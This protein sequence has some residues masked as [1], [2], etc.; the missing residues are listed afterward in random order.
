[1]RFTESMFD[2]IFQTIPQLSKI[3]PVADKNGVVHEVNFQ[4]PR[5][6]VDYVQQIQKD[7]GIDVSQYMPEDE[8]QLR[9]DILAKGHTWIGIETQGTATMIDYLYKKVTRPKIIG[10]AFIV[11]YP[12]TMQPLARKSDIN[13]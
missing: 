5:Q 12:A 6:R 4:T 9:A 2:Y 8:E 1:M 7:S 11:N 3:V 10:P 13:P